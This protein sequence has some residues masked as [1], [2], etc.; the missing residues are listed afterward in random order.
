MG[1]LSRVKLPARLV[2]TQGP[3]A[4]IWQHLTFL[5][6]QS[7]VDGPDFLILPPAL[8]H[9]LRSVSHLGALFKTHG[10]RQEGGRFGTS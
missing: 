8:V 3:C 9:H 5:K 6:C 4:P 10:R 2:S 7:H 1:A